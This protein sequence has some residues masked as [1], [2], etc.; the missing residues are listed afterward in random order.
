MALLIQGR[1]QRAA[2]G[3]TLASLALASAGTAYAADEDGQLWSIVNASR[4]LDDKTTFNLDTQAR[5]TNDASRLGQAIIRP[6]IGWKLGG[7]KTGSLGYAYVR[8]TPEGRPTTHEHRGWQQL[9]FR[10]AG[11]G[12][13]ATLTGRTRL[14]Q[15]WMEGR[16]GA[17]WR[18]RQQ[19]RLTAPINDGVRGVAWTEAFVGLNETGWGQRDGLHLWR[20]FAGVSVPISK[21]VTLEPG[22]LHQRAYRVGPDAVTHA[23]AVWINL[24]F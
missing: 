15:R 22:Y 19:V 4:A 12:K 18:V 24:Q 3:L 11:D 20:S 1:G 13:G 8:T 10:V 16:D 9:S 14:E 7:S 23:A 21:T 17:G 2:L 5:F 6:S